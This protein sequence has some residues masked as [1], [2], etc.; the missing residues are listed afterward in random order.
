MSDRMTRAAV[1]GALEGPDAVRV[2]DWPSRAP[3]PGEVRLKVRAASANF[4]DLLMT[5]G[6]YQHKA[7]PPFVPGLECAGEIID[8]GEGVT[9]WKIGDR[10]VGMVG[11]AG[12]GF[13][14]ETT[15]PAASLH[16]SPPAMSDVEAASLYVGHYTGYVGLIDRGRLQ[17]GETAVIFGAAG[18]VGLG[19]VQIALALGAKVIATASSEAKRQLLRDQGVEH[20][21]A[22]ADPELREKIKEIGG[23]GVDLVYDPVNGEVFDLALRLLRPE[24]R[25]CVI[26]FAGGPI[27]PAP[28]NIVLIKEIEVIG[29]RAGQFGRRHPEKMREAWAR[30]SAWNAEGKLTPHVSRT[31]RLDEA[32]EAL[33]ALESRE[34]VGKIAVVMD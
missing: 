10:A 13:A 26:G 7:E 22:P 19:A 1:C 16:P 17:P 24:G 34:V 30:M 14:E 28:S 4:P 9:D 2:Q 33:K 3:G 25:L 15:L 11:A 8:V 12:A 6:L 20:V 31:Y 5:R 21:L 18:G 29:V 27:R 23:G 32:A